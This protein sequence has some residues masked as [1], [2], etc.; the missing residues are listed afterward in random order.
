MPGK[1]QKMGIEYRTFDILQKRQLTH[2]AL[3][4][5]ALINAVEIA[6]KHE[7]RH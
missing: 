2:C 3:S 4:L 6:D 1:S 7:K 5:C